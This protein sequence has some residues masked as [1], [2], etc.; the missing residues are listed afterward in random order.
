[1]HKK[2]PV[3]S[4]NVSNNADIV[5]DSYTPIIFFQG[6]TIIFYLYTTVLGAGTKSF[7]YW[8]MLVFPLLEWA[9]RFCSASELYVPSD[10]LLITCWIEN[11]GLRTMLLNFCKKISKEMQIFYLMNHTYMHHLLNVVHKRIPSIEISKMLNKNHQK[12]ICII[13]IVLTKS[14]IK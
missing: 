1:M 2:T 6:Y 11:E 5:I 7:R 9:S 3:S 8:T 14:S 12:F 4:F 10:N 13:V